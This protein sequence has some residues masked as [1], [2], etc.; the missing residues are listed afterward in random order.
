MNLYNHF[1]LAYFTIFSTSLSIIIIP[2]L[3]AST[4]RPC[5]LLLLSGS[6]SFAT[7]TIDL[8]KCLRNISIR[9]YADA[10]LD[11]YQVFSELLPI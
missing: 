8:Q 9:Q 7:L 5:Y 3:H 1:I 10:H 4:I 11:P 6:C 2:F